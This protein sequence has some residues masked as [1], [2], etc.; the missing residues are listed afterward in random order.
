MNTSK[1]KKRIILTQNILYRNSHRK[2]EEEKKTKLN[3]KTEKKILCF[4]TLFF[5]IC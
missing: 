3:T 1:V 2:E 5:F 4:E